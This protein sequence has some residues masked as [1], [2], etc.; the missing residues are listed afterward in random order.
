MRKDLFNNLPGMVMQL[1]RDEGIDPR[2]VFQ[3][4]FHADAL[5]PSAHIAV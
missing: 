2:E 3:L 4:S 5:P 1:E